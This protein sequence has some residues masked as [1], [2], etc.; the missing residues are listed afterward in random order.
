MVEPQPS[1][2]MTRVRFPSPAPSKHND[3]QQGAARALSAELLELVQ[4]PALNGFSTLR[5]TVLEVHGNVLC[6]LGPPDEGRRWLQQA[7]TLRET[8]VGASDPGTATLRLA[9][10]A[11]MRQ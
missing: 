5:S 9:L 1:K 8:L 4:A 2:L 3:F 10:S 11:C 6:A 7:S